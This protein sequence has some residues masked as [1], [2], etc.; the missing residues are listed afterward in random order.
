ME[1]LMMLLMMEIDALPLKI[2]V[3]SSSCVLIEMVMEVA[4]YGDGGAAGLRPQVR[5]WMCG[6]FFGSSPLYLCLGG[7][8]IV[9]N[10]F[11]MT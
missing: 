2:L 7:S 4:A 8:P 9:P 6:I 3:S 1:I 5:V 11:L 10:T